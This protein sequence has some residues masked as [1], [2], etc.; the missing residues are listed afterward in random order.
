MIDLSKEWEDAVHWMDIQ[1]EWEDAIPVIAQK[2][3]ASFMGG[4]G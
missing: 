3:P 1:T 2:E 4:V